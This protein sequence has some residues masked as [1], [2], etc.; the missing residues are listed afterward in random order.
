MVSPGPTDDQLIL[1][2]LFHAVAHELP[3]PEV[4]TAP[5]TY[6]LADKTCATDKYNTT[7]P[8]KHGVFPRQNVPNTWFELRKSNVDL[9]G[10]ETTTP[11][12]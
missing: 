8:A 10:Y 6:L 4:A 7:S 3:F 2:G 1:P 9:L 12:R 11:T 5:L